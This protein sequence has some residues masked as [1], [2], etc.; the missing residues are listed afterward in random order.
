MLAYILTVLFIPLA[1]VI[2]EFAIPAIRPFNRARL[3]LIGTLIQ[4]ALL[5]SFLFS[6]I[7]IYRA[8][9]FIERAIRWIHTDML[10]ASLG[11][12]CDSVSVLM[13]LI[14]SVFS[15]LFLIY[16]LDIHLNAR[17][18]RFIIGTMFLLSVGILAPDLIVL[19][20]CWILID[21]M[22]FIFSATTEPESPDKTPNPQKTPWW[23]LA[24][25]C[26]IIAIILI[27]NH[28][29]SFRFTVIFDAIQ[30]GRI[31]ATTLTQPH[32]WFSLA[33]FGRLMSLPTMYRLILRPD[34]RFTFM[35]FL[36]SLYQTVAA[37]YLLFRV[38]PLF[39]PVPAF[40]MTYFFIFGAVLFI[41]FA[42][43]QNSLTILLTW[44]VTAQALLLP[45]LANLLAI[46]FLPGL[47]LSYI[48]SNFGLLLFTL[49]FKYHLRPALSDNA[50]SG[51]VSE[52]T[53]TGLKYVFL[54]SVLAAIGIPLSF[55]F[56]VRAELLAIVIHL[57]Q[58]N[59]IHILLLVLLDLAI[60]MEAYLALKLIRLV[61]LRLKQEIFDRIGLNQ[62]VAIISGTI[63]YV[64]PIY[65][66][67]KWSPVSFDGH[68]LMNY[69]PESLRNTI[70]PDI[71]L[72]IPFAIFLTVPVLTGI[73]LL[74]AWLFNSNRFA[75]FN[76]I[77]AKMIVFKQ[78][79][80]NR[81]YFHAIQRLAHRIVS[82][83]S[84]SAVRFDS[85]LSEQ[86]LYRI[87]T[88]SDRIIQRCS[89]GIACSGRWFTRLSRSLTRPLYRCYQRIQNATLS[90]L[91]VALIII[92]AAL[93]IVSF[94]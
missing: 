37:V 20:I 86:I 55:G 57:I 24:D 52:R 8:D 70:V 89:T 45:A 49:T 51:L 53:A 34:P 71:H 91:M 79:C 65:T 13:L 29:R 92:I 39:S 19:A 76:R 15:S 67:P 61:F 78:I 22:I 16:G 56:I 26:L 10:Q 47:L 35:G 58:T 3:M 2:T 14:I 6:G 63:F 81:I 74:T 4:F 1:L 85:F 62:L 43:H 44:G 18:Y 54:L 42:I 11:I 75:M 46:Q 69:L 28:T 32:V 77:D 84:V 88:K 59:P 36:F 33:I 72:P 27:F 94:F 83:V 30:S 48:S 5:L 41:L 80:R 82:G 12:Y 7:F 93:V 25:F 68:W 73:G 60:I 50:V 90:N 87:L 38:F 40:I 17:Q 31:S 21:G 66:L 9:F 64:F 23:L